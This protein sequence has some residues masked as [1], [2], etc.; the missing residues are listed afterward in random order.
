MSSQNFCSSSK[1]SP[2]RPP[3]EKLVRA[4]D[5]VLRNALVS[6][7]VLEDV[8]ELAEASENVSL[9]TDPKL[10]VAF[11]K[12]LQQYRVQSRVRDFILLLENGLLTTSSDA[13]C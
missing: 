2:L 4:L 7:G 11:M 8:L 12:L 1:S 3:G 13:R 9:L 5:C 6:T 10:I